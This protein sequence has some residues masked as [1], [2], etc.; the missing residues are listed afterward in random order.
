MSVTC[1]GLCRWCQCFIDIKWIIL[2]SINVKANDHYKHLRLRRS[3]YLYWSSKAR[4]FCGRLNFF[5]YTQTVVF[6]SLCFTSAS[7]CIDLKNR[8]QNSKPLDY[9][10]QENSISP[11]ITF[12]NISTKYKYK[13]HST[14]FSLKVTSWQFSGT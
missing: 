3:K 1:K 10:T 7:K 6:C 9:V 4:A 12:Y 2:S 8:I 11:P 14:Q 13:M 5:E